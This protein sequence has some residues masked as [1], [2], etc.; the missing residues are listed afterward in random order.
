LFTFREAGMQVSPVTM[1]CPAPRTAVPPCLPRSI[2]DP[3]KE[4]GGLL[5]FACG[6]FDVGGFGREKNCWRRIA[7]EEFLKWG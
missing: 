5:L 3:L 1:S 6:L 7:K 2:K 4:D